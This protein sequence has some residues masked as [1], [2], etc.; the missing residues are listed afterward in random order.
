MRHGSTLT[1]DFWPPGSELCL[2]WRGQAHQDS[3]AKGLIG[4]ADIGGLFH[5][6]ITLRPRKPSVAQLGR[7]DSTWRWLMG[8]RWESA[9]PQNRSGNLPDEAENAASNAARVGPFECARLFPLES[10]T[11][12]RT[13]YNMQSTHANAARKPHLTPSVCMSAC[14]LSL[15]QVLGWQKCLD[16]DLA[17]VN[18]RA[19]LF[20]PRPCLGP[21][22]A[23][24][25]TSLWLLRTS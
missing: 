1:A 14:H 9:N 21:R 7:R 5:S 12:H 22:R 18:L 2:A 3:L 8:A 23:V 20:R 24:K 17:L 10:C 13:K 4:I 11:L 19:V 16:V 15:F 6:R 25:S